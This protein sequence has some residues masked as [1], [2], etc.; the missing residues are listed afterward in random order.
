MNG[1]MGTILRVDLTEGKISKETMP[2]ELAHTY[3]GGRG[4]NARVLYDEVKPGTDPLGPD[5]KLI[6]G[7]GPCNGTLVPGSQRFTVTFKS[8]ITGR[9]GDSNS[10]GSF[11]ATLKYAGYD[12]VIIEGQAKEPVYLWI[13]D[14]KVEIRSA[15]HLWG[16]TTREASRQI[17]TELQDP[18]ISTIVIGP[19]GE[20]LVRFASVIADLGRALGRAGVGAVFGSKKL[21]AVSV[22]GSKGVKVAHPERLE[23]AVRQT[24][25]AWNNNRTMYD[26]V[27][28]YGPSRGALRYGGML[29]DKNFSGGQPTGWFSMMSYENQ[30]ERYVKTRACFSC[31]QGCDHMY[32]VTKGPF[33]GTYGEGIELSQP[34]DYGTKIGLYDFD[35]VLAMG[36]LGDE[37][38]LDYFDSSSLIAYAIE[39]FEKGILTEK[40]TD[41]LRL[42]WGNQDALPKLLS[43]IARREGFGNILAEGLERAPKMIG[44]GTEKYAM[45]ARGMTFAGRDPRS[46]K[47]WGLMYAVSSRGPCHVRAFLPES[48]PDHGWDVSLDKIL[49][50]Y[51]D[52]KNRVLEEGKPELVYWYENLVAFKNS[53]E[54]C[55]FSSD[56][57]MFSPTA[58]PFSIPGMLARFYNATTGCNI[59]EEDLLHTGERIVNVERAFNVR[60]G[61]TRKDDRLPERML[62]EPMP[63]G[64]A[65]GQVVDLEPMLDEYY[66]HRQWDQAS[67]LPTRRKLEELKLDDIATELEALGKLAK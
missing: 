53:L 41:G 50:K 17:M 59:S 19:G 10:G 2:E 67:G 1:W 14:D 31:S 61:L 29:G 20:N 36:A 54:I 5:N 45:Q 3:I 60:E 24:Y 18:N 64:F 44:R 65:K 22:R 13:D 34:M 16:K 30:A 15:R 46:S 37:L 42:E 35:A 66:A 49:K 25:D 52:P 27:A 57:W 43:M 7:V 48:M 32:V 9:Y 21:K 40:D 56:P 39:C 4:L 58:K 38:G 63:D 8:P 23:E 6:L 47:G 28:G 12:M 51:K 26:L 62:N 33:K 11:G 55:L